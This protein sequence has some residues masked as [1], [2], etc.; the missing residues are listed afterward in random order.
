MK[1]LIN[2]MKWLV[3]KLRK[4]DYITFEGKTIKDEPTEI[5]VPDNPSTIRSV[6][7]TI[8]RL[9]NEDRIE[10]LSG[11]TTDS[12]NPFNGSGIPGASGNSGNQV[13]PANPGNT[14][15]AGNQDLTGP[16]IDSST[17]TEVKT[18]ITPDGKEKI[19]EKVTVKQIVD[20]RDDTKSKIEEL[21]A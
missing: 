12:H 9:R 3:R 8:N 14:G 1:W 6:N 10:V 16:T 7:N 11:E 5:T 17:T 13:S 15:N 4:H 18:E 2:K 20:I 19:I 21:L